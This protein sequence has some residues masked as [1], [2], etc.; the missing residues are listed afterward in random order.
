[1]FRNGRGRSLS[2]SHSMEAENWCADPPPRS[3]RRRR[4]SKPWWLRYRCVFSPPPRSPPKR[5]A[6]FFLEKGT[7]R[8]R[9]RPQK[10]KLPLRLRRYV[11][12]FMMV[13]AVRGGAP[14]PLQ[15]F[16]GW[17][18][19]S[20]LTAVPPSRRRHEKRRFHKR[21]GPESMVLRLCYTPWN[22]YLPGFPLLFPHP[23]RPPS[24]SCLPSVNSRPSK[25]P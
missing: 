3:P 11:F 14:T 1:M 6:T 17:R 18:S 5:P 7:R 25:S 20:V 22:A 19:C 24:R 21:H 10:G 23:V 15:A 8:I 13:D 2:E 4:R 16:N 12:Y 9:E